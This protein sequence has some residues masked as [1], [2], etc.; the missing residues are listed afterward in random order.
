MLPFCYLSWFLRYLGKSCF[1]TGSVIGRHYYNAKV[2]V[3]TIQKV[4]NNRTI[5]CDVIIGYRQWAIDNLCITRWIL[6]ECSRHKVAM[7]SVVGD[8]HG[9]GRRGGEGAE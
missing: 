4:L 5:D 3:I 8:W 7:R 1:S 2:V 9:Y 6:K